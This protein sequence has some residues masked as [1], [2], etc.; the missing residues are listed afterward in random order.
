L[1]LGA[2]LT[3]I[4]LLAVLV[5]SILDKIADKKLKRLPS[6]SE[7]INFKAI[8]KFDVR[9]WIISFVT[10]TYYSGILPFIAIAEYS[11]HFTQK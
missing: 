5:Y 6:P 1:F 2:L 8:V 7:N 11:T 9:F 4:S 3:A 10:L